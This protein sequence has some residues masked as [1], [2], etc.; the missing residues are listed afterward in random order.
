MDVELEGYD[1][2][3]KFE[4]LK[5]RGCEF[6]P[7]E[8]EIKSYVWRENNNP[9]SKDG[10]GRF[11]EKGLHVYKMQSCWSKRTYYFLDC[12]PEI[13]VYTHTDGVYPLSMLRYSY[14]ETISKLIQKNLFKHADVIRSIGNERFNEYCGF[15]CKLNEN[16]IDLYYSNGNYETKNEI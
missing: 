6:F 2:I 15:T 13:E 5:K 3:K 1:L 7:S 14:D 11:Q 4:S 8:E 16:R 9:V 10:I 12:E